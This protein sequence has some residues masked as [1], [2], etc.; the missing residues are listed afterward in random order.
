MEVIIS[1]ISYAPMGDRTSNY[2]IFSE[3]PAVLHGGPPLRCSTGM[4]ELSSHICMRL[5]MSSLGH[6]RNRV[7]WIFV[8]WM[9]EI[10]E[11]FSHVSSDFR[12]YTHSSSSNTHSHAA[13]TDLAEMHLPAG[14][15]ILWGSYRNVT[16]PVSA[17]TSGWLPAYHGTWFYGLWSILHHG[18]F[19]ESTDEG[20]GGISGVV[21]MP[22]ILKLARHLSQSRTFLP[23][24][25]PA[26]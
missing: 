1:D 15:Q 3:V 10:T 14:V 4:L 11:M 21:P 6:L 16:A 5:Y 17:E 26:K 19:L 9:F 8:S 20:R 22:G 7:L 24:S 13:G 18:I 2:E 12:L 25:N 23:R